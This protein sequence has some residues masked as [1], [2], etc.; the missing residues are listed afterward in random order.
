M[1]NKIDQDGILKA[2]ERLK[3]KLKEDKLSFKD[4]KLSSNK[5]RKQVDASVN[6]HQVKPHKATFYLSDK[7]FELLDS[8]YISRYSEGD[9]SGKSALICEAIELLAVKQEKK[10][11][12]GI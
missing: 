6:P 4:Y 3:Q 2:A 5:E 11:K 12:K 7:A 10:K 9:K 1:T 8:I